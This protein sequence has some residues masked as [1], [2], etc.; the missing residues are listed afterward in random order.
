LSGELLGDYTITKFRE[1]LMKTAR[2]FLEVTGRTKK[3][4]EDP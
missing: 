4:I 2:W 1:G 3:C